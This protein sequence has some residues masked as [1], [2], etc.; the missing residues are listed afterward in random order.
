MYRWKLNRGRRQLSDRSVNRLLSIYIDIETRLA[1]KLMV[2][3][4]WT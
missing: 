3:R 4:G 2:G 1:R